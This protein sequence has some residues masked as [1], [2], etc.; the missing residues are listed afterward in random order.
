MSDDHPQT[1]SGPLP[2]AGDRQRRNLEVKARLSSVAAAR[3]VARRLATQH[4]GTQ[5]QTDTY[6]RCPAGRLKLRTIDGGPAQLVWYVRPDQREAALSCYHLVEVPDG[7]A[8]GQALT[9]ALG[10]WIV[11]RKRREVFLHHNVRIHLDEVD[12]LGAF[13]E[14][15]AVLGPDANEA[16]C[17]AR[18][19]FLSHEFRL[20]SADLLSDSYSDMVAALAG[21]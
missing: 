17:R 19:E 10:T 7:N 20:A 21:E 3:E 8:L 1:A 18:L 13:L 2:Q 9:A 14:F 15:E 6:F 11:V 16:T 12:Q 5:I 4:L